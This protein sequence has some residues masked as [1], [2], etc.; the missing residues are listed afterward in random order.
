MMFRYLRSTTMLGLFYDGKNINLVGFT[1][2]DWA[3]D[4]DS[5]T[6][7]SSHCL[8]FAD[9]VVSWSS[10]KQTSTTISSLETK[11]VSHSSNKISYFANEITWRLGAC[12]INWYT[13]VMR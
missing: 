10:K 9:G 13:F 11:Y 7:T 6:S 3:R 4:F 2:V 5:M 8:T 1:Y 12:K